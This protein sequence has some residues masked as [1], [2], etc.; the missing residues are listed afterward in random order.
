[1]SDLVRHSSDCVHWSPKGE[2][3]RSEGGPPGNGVFPKLNIG[4]R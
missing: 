3:G 4:N 2:D 1:M